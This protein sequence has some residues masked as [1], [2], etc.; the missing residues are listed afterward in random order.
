MDGALI[1]WFGPT[2]TR[3]FSTPLILASNTRLALAFS[4]IRMTWPI[5][6]RILMYCKMSMKLRSSYIS[7]SDW[8]L[9]PHCQLALDRRHY[10]GLFSR[11]FSRQ[12]HKEVW[13]K[14]T[15]CRE[16][17]STLL[18]FGKSRPTLVQQADTVFAGT[19][20]AR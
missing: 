15:T 6:H 20:K 9:F 17:S 3:S 14:R 7:L 13:L 2:Q 19:A 5:H 11:I 4:S 12:Q 8:M 16:F 18:P 10:V 1:M